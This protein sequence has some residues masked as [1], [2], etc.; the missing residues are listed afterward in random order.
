MQRLSKRFWFTALVGSLS[1]LLLTWAVV[2]F[3]AVQSR[4][5]IALCRLGKDWCA[6]RETLG[7]LFHMVAIAQAGGT[8]LLFGLAYNVGR[9]LLRPAAPAP[10]PGQ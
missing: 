9:R 8:I 7:H 3:F 6:S 10:G 1:S 5:M 4:E 2:W